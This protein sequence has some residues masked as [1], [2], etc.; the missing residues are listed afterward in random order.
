MA[1]F[2]VKGPINDP[3]VKSLPLESLKTG[4]TG[5]AKL[6]FNVL[7]NTITLPKTILFPKNSQDSPSTLDDQ[8]DDDQEF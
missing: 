6:A 3:V 1:V 4:L 8:S 2:E 5:F 7:K